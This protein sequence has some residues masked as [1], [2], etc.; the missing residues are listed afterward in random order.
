MGIA[1]YK[2]LAGKSLDLQSRVI[3]IAY[4]LGN[5]ADASIAFNVLPSFQELPVI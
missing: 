4:T 3:I 1:E 2:R 5:K